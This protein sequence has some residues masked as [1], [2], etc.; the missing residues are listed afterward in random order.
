[1]RNEGAGELQN[2]GQRCFGVLTVCFGYLQRL[3]PYVILELVLPGGT[4]V[5]LSLYVYRHKRPQ[6]QAM[7]DRARLKSAST[8]R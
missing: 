3:G 8:A 2:Y 1:M 6:L 7:L 5:A 4:L